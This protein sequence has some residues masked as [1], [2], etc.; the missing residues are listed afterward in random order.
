MAEFKINSALTAER[1]RDWRKEPPLA[2]QTGVEAGG[3]NGS[4]A[5]GGGGG[6]FLTMIRGAGGRLRGPRLPDGKI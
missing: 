1:S 3:A 5:Q 6:T 2:P 4:G